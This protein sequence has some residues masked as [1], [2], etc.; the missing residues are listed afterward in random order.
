MS[1]HTKETTKI[2]VIKPP[3]KYRY[4]HPQDLGVSQNSS[5]IRQETEVAENH[6]LF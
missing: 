5:V 1:V 3:T 4:Q 6:V 2:E